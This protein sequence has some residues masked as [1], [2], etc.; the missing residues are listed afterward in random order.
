MQPEEKSSI[1]ISFAH[2]TLKYGKC[3]KLQLSE[4]TQMT[5]R[6]KSLEKSA[7]IVCATKCESCNKHGTQGC[8]EEIGQCICRPNYDGPKCDNCVKGYTLDNG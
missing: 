3:Y 8:N 5:T 6:I 4:H 7:K 2:E 1:F